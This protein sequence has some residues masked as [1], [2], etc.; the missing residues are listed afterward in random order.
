MNSLAS[1]CPQNKGYVVGISSIRLY[2]I[3]GMKRGG[4]KVKLPRCMT[5]RSSRYHQFTFF[6]S[7]KMVFPFDSV[8]SLFVSPLI[9]FQ[10]FSLNSI[11]GKFEYEENG[12]WEIWIKRKNRK[13]EKTKNT[14]F[15]FLHVNWW[16]MV[17]S[18]I[19]NWKGEMNEMNDWLEIVGERVY[20][21]LFHF[22]QSQQKWSSWKVFHQRKV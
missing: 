9:K 1:D 16:K 3:R 17:I 20:P 13:E 18:I 2:I 5:K 11:W 22:C 6:Y 19:L 21:W 8:Y 12:K 7:V 4:T 14:I 15:H 10:S